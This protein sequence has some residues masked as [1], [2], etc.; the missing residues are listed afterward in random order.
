MF[1][2]SSESLLIM[3]YTLIEAFITISIFIIFIETTYN[4]TL[5]KA[6]EYLH[7]TNVL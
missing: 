7:Y 6:Y 5:N 3:I 4:V 2:D 1:Y